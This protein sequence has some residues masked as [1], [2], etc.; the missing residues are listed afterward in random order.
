MS[1][2]P[3][4]P[5]VSDGRSGRTRSTRVRSLFRTT[6][7][8]VVNERE[9][10]PPVFGRCQGCR[11]PV[12]SPA[13]VEDR[14]RAGGGW[15][16]S[17]GES[18]AWR[19]GEGWSGRPPGRPPRL[20]SGRPHGEGGC[21]VRALWVRSP[22]TVMRPC[23]V[24]VPT[25]LVA[26]VTGRRCDSCCRT[27][28]GSQRV[29]V[30]PVHLDAWSDLASG[31]IDSAGAVAMPSACR[32]GSPGARRQRL[33]EEAPSAGGRRERHRQRLRATSEDSLLDR[34][35][36]VGETEVGHGVQQLMHATSALA[37]SAPTQK[38]RPSAKARW[39]AAAENAEV[40]V[41]SSRKMS[42]VSGSR[43]RCSS[44]LA[45]PMRQVTVAPAGMVPP[46][47]ST[48]VADCRM[49]M[50]TGGV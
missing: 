37:S 8:N 28:R 30:A 20:A 2:T 32:A 16:A 26:V 39:S 25:T 45:A 34:V 48:S 47:S 22:G 41:R 9:D 23:F 43:K 36:T 7:D 38:C 15:C 42:N 50:W 44:R 5:F 3:L 21:G 18:R 27:G 46:V 13:V 24:D 6:A 12:F 1:L 40:V 33:G 10:A 19:P 17:F 35:E 4:L 31:A 49:I 11:N 29:D 14:I